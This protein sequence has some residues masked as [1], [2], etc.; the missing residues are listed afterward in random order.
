[1]RFRPPRLRVEGDAARLRLAR[2]VLFATLTL[3]VL[4]AGAWRWIPFVIVATG[5]FVSFGLAVARAREFRLDRLSVVLLALAAWSGLQA[6]PAGPL[7]AWLSPRAAEL[8]ALPPP[9]TGSSISYEAGASAGEAVKYLLYFMVVF[10]AHHAFR[11]RSARSLLQWVV[12]TGALSVAVAGFHDLF[13]FDELY[14]AIPWRLGEDRRWT[15]LVN[16]N[17]GT[18]LTAVCALVALGLARAARAR[19]ETALWHVAAVVFGGLTLV[20]GSRAG[21]V[22]FALGL[23]GWLLLD[24]LRASDRRPSRGGFALGALGIAAAGI[25]TALALARRDEETFGLKEKLAGARD[26]IPLVGD[27]LWTGIGRGA[28]ASTYSAY[29]SSALELDFRFPEN[30]IAQ[31]VSE[32]GAPIG[33]AALLLLGIGLFGALLADRSPLAQSSA[34]AAAT[35]VFHNLADFSLELPGVAMIFVVLLGA[36]RIGSRA[37]VA[38][39]L[40][41]PGRIALLALGGALLSVG[42]SAAY[43]GDVNRTKRALDAAIEARIETGEPEPLDPLFARANRHPA[44]ALVWTKLAYL[45]TL[46]FASE[47]RRATDAVNR[48]LFLAP[49]YPD[50]HLIAGRLLVRA[51]IRRQ[52]LAEMRR[53]WELADRKGRIAKEIVTWTQSADDLLYALPRREDAPDQPRPAELAWAVS[54]LWTHDRRDVAQ[55][56]IGHAPPPDAVPVRD[57]YVMGKAAF[58]TGRTGAAI[59]YLERMVRESPN[60]P[61]GWSRLI[62]YALSSERTDLAVAASDRAGAVGLDHWNVTTARLAAAR[63][64]GDWNRVDT[65]LAQIGPV[66]RPDRKRQLELLRIEALLEEGRFAPAVER[67]TQLL[68]AR[69]HEADARWLRARG[70]ASLG[71]LRSARRD[72][73]EV[74][75][76][77]PGH[78]EAR[79][80]LDLISGNRKDGAPQSD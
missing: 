54:W 23:I 70:L 33:G 79:R 14:G 31:L 52:G 22:A 6:L 62:Q 61:R 21:I 64:A 71:R 68:T 47:R 17:H 51:G 76:R 67:A 53:A 3:G 45:A 37:A 25:A 35:V 27:H 55:A 75:R 60:D 13:G 40:N 59:A 2:A 19:R 77:R 36:G 39:R 46:D 38:P 24:V 44:N 1:M 32:W 80:L 11:G 34:V 58:Q 41:A 73:A 29:K 42:L 28:F 50:A 8:R 12:W 9:A 63:A 69:P 26:V 30:L 43:R 72:L 48:A 4:L 65:I 57:L 56:L 16:P 7:L 5:A 15:T 49:T 20:Q 66:K 74:L 10:V 18:A 78:A